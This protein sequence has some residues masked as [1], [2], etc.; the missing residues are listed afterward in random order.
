MTTP[1]PGRP[2]PDDNIRKSRVER[3]RD[4]IRRD[5]QQARTGRH[6]VPTWLMATVLGLILAG[7][8][9]LIITR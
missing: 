2:G 5:V 6:I 3:R 9:Y 7:W 1:A 4:R 8:L